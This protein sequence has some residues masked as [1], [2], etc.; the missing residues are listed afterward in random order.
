MAITNFYIDSGGNDMNAGSVV[1][2]AASVTQTNGSWDITADTFIAT[3]GTPFSGVNVGDYASIYNDGVT[4]GAVYVAQV[5]TINSL[6]LSITLSTT[7][8]YG[9]KPASGATGK[10]CKIGGSWL[11]EIPLTSL[12]ATTVPQNTK[13]NIKA[14]T[15]TFA[16]ARTVALVGTTTNRL[17]IDGYNTS[18]GDLDA[19]RTNA[20]TKPTLAFGTNLLTTSGA[21]QMWSNLNC[22]STR[23][24]TAWTWSGNQ[25]RM[26][27]V[28]LECTSSNSNVQAVNFTGNNSDVAYCWF[29]TPSTATVNPIVGVAANGAQATFFG[30]VTDGGGTGQYGAIPIVTDFINCI[31]RNAAGIAF[32][33]STLSMRVIY[34]TVYN[35]TT[36]AVKWT[37]TPGIGSAVIGCLFSSIGGIG[38]NNGSGTNSS[39][40]LR[41]GNDFYSCTGGNEVGFGDDPAWYGSTE[42]SDP[43]TSSTDMTPVT[44]SSA[45]NDGTA[46]IF[47]NQS[48][49]G[50][51]WCGAV[52]KPWAAA[53][54]GSAV[55][56]FGS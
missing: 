15:Y 27:R 5:T 18:P 44:S 36:D 9:T 53:T 25:P 39:N 52:T 45:V 2:A 3:G 56:I 28:R 17:W 19:D 49:S 11:D 48:Y 29:K 54:G 55:A 37:G 51:T 41:V 33:A 38:I 50:G 35:S 7:I 24:T 6:G 43:M 34:C 22:T 12:G 46:G 26:V 4:T 32:R 10:S 40:I 1:N 31:S 8:K 42:G 21:Y 16:A 14:G 23:T 20:L 30:C 47:E 13:V